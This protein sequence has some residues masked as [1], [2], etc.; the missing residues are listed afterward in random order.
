MPVRCSNQLSYEATDVGSCVVGSSVPVMN[1]L[2]NKMI[3]EMN[4]IIIELW[5]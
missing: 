3:Y 1:K 2:M 4:P 5:N